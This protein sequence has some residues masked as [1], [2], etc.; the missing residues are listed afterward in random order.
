MAVLGTLNQSKK[1]AGPGQVYIVAHPSAGYTGA[2]D[3]LRMAS[4]KALFFSDSAT[5][6][7][8]VL[9]PS[10]YSD[11]SAVGIEVKLKTAPIEF[12]PN[13]GGKYKAANGPTECSVTWDFKDADANK[14]LDAFSAVAG[15]LVTT[16]SGTGI[17]GRKTVFIGRQGAPLEVAILVRYPSEFAG[18]FRNIFIPY[19]TMNPEWDLKIDKKSIAI[20]K[21]V[22]TAINDWTLLGT[23]AMPP[24]ALIDD[25]IAAGS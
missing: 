10:A 25:V 14:I 18:E 9:I 11:I 24:V 19:A 4:V 5:D 21:C 15:D 23:N 22:A 7:C 8:R 16:A 12:D 13:A 3:T 6:A 1:I 17:A 20:V 2:T